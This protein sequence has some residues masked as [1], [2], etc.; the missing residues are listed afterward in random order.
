VSTTL[1]TAVGAAPTA[2]AAGTILSNA[3]V[4]PT[5]SSDPSE[6]D[7]AHLINFCIAAVVAT[8]ASVLAVSLSV[9]S[10]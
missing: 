4:T 3:T 7:G 10:G 2:A 1:G 5:T 9:P 6:A 8:T